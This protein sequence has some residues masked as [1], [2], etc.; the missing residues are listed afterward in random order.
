MSMTQAQ[1]LAALTDEM[2]ATGS[3]QWSSGTLLSWLDLAFWQ[4]W[5]NILNANNVYYSQS[6]TVTQ[7]VNGQFAIS[8]LTT[9]AADAVKNFYRI[10]SLAQPQGGNQP[11]LFYRQTRYKDYPNPQPNQGTYLSGLWY[12]IG[13]QIQVMPVANGQQ[14]SV[15]VNYRPPRPSQLSGSSVVVD[16]PDG[17]EMLLVF[18]AAMFALNKGGSETPAA[19]TMAQMATEIRSMMLMDL[20]RQGT[21]PIVAESFDR[22]EDWAG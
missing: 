15:Q 6:V 4:E 19:N 17:Y 21:W 7:D 3:T 13:T 14:M 12:R 10:L 5:A 1:L 22:P 16:F 11:Q 2:N 18:V 9:G 8:A 20:A